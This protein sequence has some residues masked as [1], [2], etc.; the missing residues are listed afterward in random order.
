MWMH[1]LKIAKN[2]TK[3]N[4]LNLTKWYFRPKWK[5]NIWSDFLPV[6]K[7]RIFYSKD[8]WLIINK[9]QNF[10]KPS[11]KCVGHNFSMVL[12]VL[13]ICWLLALYVQIC[14]FHP[15]VPSKIRSLLSSCSDILLRREII[16][17]L[18]FQLKQ[19]SFFLA[20]QYFQIFSALFFSSQRTV[21][22]IVVR[23][24]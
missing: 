17:F 2:M 22:K 7:R 18:T 15:Q 13:I 10:S 20:S 4:L 8:N 3:I 5:F 6:A 23:C 24:K 12:C 16:H 19:T 9:I 21:V 14:R 1:L 11:K